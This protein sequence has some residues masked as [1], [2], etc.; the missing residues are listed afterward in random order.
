M[1]HADQSQSMSEA[2]VISA[3]ADAV[4]RGLTIEIDGGNQHTV[5]SISQSYSTSVD[6]LWEACTNPERLERWFAPVSGELTLG[7]RYDIEGNA[8]GE[9]TACEPPRSYTIT[10][11]FGGNTSHVSVRVAPDSTE[12]ARSRLTIKHSHTGEADSDFWNQFG[13]GATGV[14]WDLSLLGLALLLEAG[15]GRPEDENAFVQSEA[16]QQFVRASSQRWG[17]ASV[18][19]GTPEADAM[20]AAERTSGFYLGQPPA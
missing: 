14:G 20:A 12:A 17:E 11:E 13:P 7:G 9:I 5:Q 10:W 2:E 4:D 16:A 15:T 19:A 18:Q 3:Q 6:D 1:T 8:S